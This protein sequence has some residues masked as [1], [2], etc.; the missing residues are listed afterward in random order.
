VRARSRAC[1]PIS[2]VRR[3]GR[4]HVRRSGRV[5][6]LRAEM[7]TM[8]YVSDLCASA[9]YAIACM[10]G[11]VAA[12]RAGMIGSIGTIWSCKTS[13]DVRRRG[14]QGA[15]AAGWRVQR[16]GNAGHCYYRRSARR[17]P[18]HRRR[19]QH[20]VPGDSS[21]RAAYEAAEA[22]AEI[23]DRPRPRGRRRTGTR[24]IDLSPTSIR[25]LPGSGPARPTQQT[26]IRRA[27]RQ[28]ESDE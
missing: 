13:P 16:R 10:A 23:A 2:T 24:L 22:V 20:P 12:N 26:T 15:C 3:P 19:A 5:R 18:A 8:A 28:G 21:P 9:A 6:S 25:P 7:P 1:S 11:E 27:T 17:V 4:R 14:R